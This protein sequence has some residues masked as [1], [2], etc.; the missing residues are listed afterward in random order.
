MRTYSVN[1]TFLSLQGEGARAGT[2]NVF[3]RFA[4]CNQTCSVSSHGFDCDTEFTSSVRLTTVEI[5]ERIK[6][7]WKASVQPSVIL[8]GGEPLLSVDNEL[9]DV[10]LEHCTVA[11]ETNGSLPMPERMMDDFGKAKL[12]VACSPKVAEHAIQLQATNE[13]RYVRSDGQGIPQPKLDAE[14]KY[15][16]PAWE[17]GSFEPGAL[18]TCRD[19]VTVNPSWS[20]SVQQHKVWSVR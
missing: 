4:G 20:L 16:S 1:E 7:L 8:T 3:V 9:A 11:V 5:L 2:A 12:F 6:L 19:L 15:L 18:S 14:F 13:L 17:R 10:L